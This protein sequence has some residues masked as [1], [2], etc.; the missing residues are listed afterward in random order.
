MKLAIAVASFAAAAL[1]VVAVTT[2]A[3]PKGAVR[4]TFTV[5]ILAQDNP[6]AKYMRWSNAFCVWAKD[7]VMVHVSAKNTGAEHVTASIK[8]RYFI[9]RGGEHGSGLTSGKDYGFDGGEFRSLWIDAGKPKGVT[10]KAK[11]ARCA[12]Y[13]FSIKSG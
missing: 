12:P 6:L 4:G 5:G 7:H 3:P 11:I 8:P 1:L 10:P 9:A 2:A 13:L